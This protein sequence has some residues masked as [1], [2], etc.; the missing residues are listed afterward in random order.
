MGED[1]TVSRIYFK[2]LRKIEKLSVCGHIVCDSAKYDEVESCLIDEF[3]E[4]FRNGDKRKMKR[5][6]AVISHFKV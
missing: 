2:I 4:A 6:A 5:T 3:R 1:E